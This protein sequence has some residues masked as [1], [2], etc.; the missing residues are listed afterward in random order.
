MPFTKSDLTMTIH[1][2]ARSA[3]E[4]LAAEKLG[5]EALEA[6]FFLWAR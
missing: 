4:Q 3:S 2:T 5:A 6:P 1:P